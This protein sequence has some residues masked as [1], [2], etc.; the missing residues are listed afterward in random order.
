MHCGEPEQLNGTYVG[1]TVARVERLRGRARP[2]TTLVSSALA[3]LLGDRLPADVAVEPHAPVPHSPPPPPQV[4]VAEP[5]LAGPGTTLSTAQVERLLELRRDQAELEDR[6]RRTIVQQ[7]EAQR[8]G[9]TELAAAFERQ[10]LHLA[11]RL[12]AV[13]HEIERLEHGDRAS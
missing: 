9:Q 3:E 4:A 7:G 8:F 11:E 10:A 6:V 1:S 13:Q 12:V 2:G 5:E